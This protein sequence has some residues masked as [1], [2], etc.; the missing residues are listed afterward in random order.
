MCDSSQKSAENS[1]AREDTKDDNNANSLD[2]ADSN[3]N[4]DSSDT[5]TK[6]KKDD[7]CGNYCNSD[8]SV[9]KP[10]SG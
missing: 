1:R 2:Y 3:V 9:S 7:G 4:D 6:M 8:V 10:V 5:T